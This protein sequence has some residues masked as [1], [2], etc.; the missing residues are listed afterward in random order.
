MKKLKDFLKTH[1]SL[2]IEF[3]WRFGLQIALGIIMLLIFISFFEAKIISFIIGYCLTS[4]VTV[5]LSTYL[6]RRTKD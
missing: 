2:L 6:S 5:S 4:L 3:G 1:K